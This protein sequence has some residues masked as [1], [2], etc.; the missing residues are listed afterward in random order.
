LGDADDLEALIKMNEDYAAKA[1]LDSDFGD[2]V[3]NLILKLR[4]E[5]IPN[6]IRRFD[7]YNALRT[8]VL[9]FDGV[10]LD[11]TRLDS[12]LPEELAPFEAELQRWLDANPKAEDSKYVDLRRIEWGINECSAMI[13]AGLDFVLRPGALPWRN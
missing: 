6:V 7:S 1:A 5:L 3:K 10:R 13:R 8:R 4:A 2:L 11:G 9:S 12:F